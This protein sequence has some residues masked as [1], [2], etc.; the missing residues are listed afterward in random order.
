MLESW[1]SIGLLRNMLHLVVLGQVEETVTS[2]EIDEETDEEIVKKRW[3]RQRVRG[4]IKGLRRRGC[5]KGA[6]T[7]GLR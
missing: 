7:T 3:V 2:R 4:M 1:K 5:D 6:A